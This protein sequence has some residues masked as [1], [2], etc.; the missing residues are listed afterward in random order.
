M[1]KQRHRGV[2]E[3]ATTHAPKSLALDL[4]KVVFV[5]GYVLAGSDGWMMSW[6]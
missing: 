4:M 1:N 3:A 6:K 5:T 2:L